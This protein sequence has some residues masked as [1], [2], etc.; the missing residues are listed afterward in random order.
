MDESAQRIELWKTTREGVQD[1]VDD[2]NFHTR[3][4]STLILAIYAAYG[5][6]W[7][8]ISTSRAPEV[9]YVALITLPSLSA[10]VGLRWSQHMK[11]FGMAIGARYKALKEIEQ[12]LPEKPFTRDLEF[13]EEMDKEQHKTMTSRLLEQLPIIFAV[14]GL[15]MTLVH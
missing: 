14:I 11:T 3:L 6:L 4:Y 13:R 10:V 8:Y 2:R 9:L 5:F 1:I 12:N 15:V 7:N